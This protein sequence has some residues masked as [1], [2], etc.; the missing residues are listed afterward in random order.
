M[1]L[2]E[3][4]TEL[5][6][7]IRRGT[8]M[9]AHIPGFVRK[10]VR[11]LER[12]KTLQYMRQYATI[13]ID[14]AVEGTPQF[15]ELE[16]NG[17]KAVKMFRWVPSTTLGDYIYLRRIDPGDMHQPLSGIPTAYW[18]DGVSRLVLS[19]TPTEAL[20][21]ELVVE[22]YSAWPTSPTATH[23]LLDYAED[24]LF[25][26]GMWN[27]A[28]HARDAELAAMH[29]GLA[30]DALTTLMNAEVDS[31]YANSDDVMRGDTWSFI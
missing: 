18:L 19:A 8:S 28:V 12:N 30:A 4:H 1:N 25:H 10:G 3:L 31:E 16:G 6:N 11:W 21:G 22:K 15:I 17:I 26:L 7:A 2:G 13:T 9:D 29:K 24:L 27:F 5:K 20:T 14:P 23:W